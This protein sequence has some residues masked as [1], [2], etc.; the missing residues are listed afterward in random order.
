M[1][2]E[3]VNVTVDAST[4][5]QLTS[6]MVGKN[7]TTRPDE[8]G[9]M[10]PG[11]AGEFLLWLWYN[12]DVRGGRF[13]IGDDDIDLWVGERIGLKGEMDSKISTLCTGENPSESPESKVAIRSGKL[14][15]EVRFGLHFNENE[16]SFTLKDHDLRLQAVRLPATSFDGGSENE[17]WGLV[18]DRMYHLRKLDGFIGGLFAQF[19]RERLEPGYAEQVGAEILA[20]L[21]Q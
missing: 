12:A 14:P 19:A 18:E 9:V 2:K 7:S 15:T 6:M 17:L 4:L 10:A 1:D 13:S 8:S 16:F 20:W 11:I 5:D 3:I 21:E